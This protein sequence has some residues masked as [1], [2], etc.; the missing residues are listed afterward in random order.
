MRRAGKCRHRVAKLK[1]AL[2]SIIRR[3][4]LKDE[5]AKTGTCSTTR[6]ENEEALKARVVISQTSNLVHHIVG[7]LLL[8]CVA[9]SCI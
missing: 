2:L 6:V 7:L 9:A 5:C 8:N 4:L 3:E 1:L